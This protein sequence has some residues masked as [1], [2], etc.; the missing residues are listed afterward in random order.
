M[1]D[2]NGGDE[3]ME[4]KVGMYVRDDQHG[5]GKVVEI[6]RC[7]E[8]EKRGFYQP[9]IKYANYEEYISTY[10][11]MQHY[12]DKA[13]EKLSDLI[14]IGDMINGMIV[15]DYSSNHFEGGDGSYSVGF[16]EIKTVITKEQIKNMEFEVGEWD[17]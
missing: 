11:N 5:I 14:E 15:E 1:S 8:C 4:L 3:I 17:V 10:N 13:K 16:D 2:D 9:Q 12:Q 7:E 6:C